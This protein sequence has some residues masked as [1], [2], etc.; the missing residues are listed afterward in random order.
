MRERLEAIIKLTTDDTYSHA[1]RMVSIRKEAEA[2]I[3]EI[4][5]AM[6]ASGAK[7][8][9]GVSSQNPPPAG[10]PAK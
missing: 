10:A 7:T 6:A 5:K 3:E 8:G 1:A 9:V 4:K 2:A